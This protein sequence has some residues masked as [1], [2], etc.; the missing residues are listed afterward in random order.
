MKVIHLI[1]SLSLASQVGAETEAIREMALDSKEPM[2]V[3]VGTSS[4]TTLIFPE[5]VDTIIGYGLTNGEAPGTFHYSHP[6]KSRLVVLRNIVPE[7][8]AFMTVVM[9]ESVF[10]FHLKSSVSPVLALKLLKSSPKAKRIEPTKIPDKRLDYS[11]TG[12]LNLLK[13]SRG[14]AVLRRHLPQVY[15]HVKSRYNVNAR[16]YYD[17]VRT[18]IHSI[19]RFPEKDTLVF[20]AELRNQTGQ[21]ITYDV[22]KLRIRVGNS[23]YAPTLADASGKIAGGSASRVYLVLTGNAEGNRS[24]LSIDNDFRLLLGPTESESAD[25]T[26]N[27]NSEG[28]K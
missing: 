17:D 6:E 21:A 28:A 19:H 26:T 8:G 13:L 7:K 20:A 9:G 24:N 4:A 22:S 5:V 3:A 23:E 10:V 1:L 12:L 16:R 2:E 14:E 25:L 27:A 11:V 15:E 18:I